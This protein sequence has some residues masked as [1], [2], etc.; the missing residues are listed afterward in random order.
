MKRIIWIA[1]STIGIIA[2]AVVVTW[3]QAA[4]SP[5][6]INVARTDSGPCV[7]VASAVPAGS[8]AFRAALEKANETGQGFLRDSKAVRAVDQALEAASQA[9][10]GTIFWG[11]TT[12]GCVEWQGANYRLV[13][14]I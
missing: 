6:I 3:L 8:L 5:G 7:L 12:H 10:F 1:I 13:R 4:D 14:I 11:G 9:Q 2:V